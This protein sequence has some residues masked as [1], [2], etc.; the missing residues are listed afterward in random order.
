MPS[1]QW[2]PLDGNMDEGKASQ[3]SKMVSCLL[4]K[5]DSVTG[6]DKLPL[7]LQG[8]LAPLGAPILTLIVL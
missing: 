2:N 3:G 7:I 8:A 5:S 4:P 6:T 1:T